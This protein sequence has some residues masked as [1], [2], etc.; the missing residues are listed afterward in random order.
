MSNSMRAKKG[1]IWGVFLLYL[2][3]LAKILFLSRLSFGDL[4][5][6]GRGVSRSVNL[7]P[8]L[9]IR[10]Y[11]SGET[12]ILRQFSYA[13]VVGNIILFM[14]LGFIL[15]TLKRNKTVAMNMII[16]LAATLF[17]EIVQWAFGIGTADIDDVILNCLGGLLGMGSYHVVNLAMRNEKNTLTAIAILCALGLPVIW[18]FLFKINMNF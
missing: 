10:A 1:I 17:A 11:L 2:L 8:F 14:P 18:L 16:I 15:P 3:L 7:M 5:D 12:E 13:N 4:F 9:S 6:T